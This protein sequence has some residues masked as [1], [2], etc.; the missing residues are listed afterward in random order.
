MK[1]DRFFRYV[2]LIFFSFLLVLS[3]CAPAATSLPPCPTVTTTSTL[4]PSP[5]RAAEESTR[6]TQPTHTARPPTLTLP[7][8]ATFINGSI[9]KIAFAS[10]DTRFASCEIFVINADGSQVIRLT[11]NNIDECCPDWS[12]DGSKLAFVQG[13]GIARE[14]WVMA[15][16]GSHPA[17]LTNNN[18]EDCC[19]AWSPDGSK[20]AFVQG[21]EREREIWVM[22]ADGSY[23]A[24]L[25]N[26]N[27][28]DCCLAWS[29]DGGKIAFVSNRDSPTGIYIMNADGSNPIRLAR[30][31][32]YFS[33]AW[34][35]DGARI[36]FLVSD[37]SV[38]PSVS[39][40]NVINADGSN[41]IQMMTTGDI[42]I[43]QFAWS[44]DGTKIAYTSC[45]LNFDS[46]E[47]Y[48]VNADGSNPTN[49]TNSEASDRFPVWSPKGAKLAFESGRDHDWKIY[50][51]NA[52]GSNPIRLIEDRDA[53]FP[54]WSPD[55]TKIAFID[56]VKGYI[57]VMNA[58][59]SA[60]ID[61]VIIAHTKGFS[62]QPILA[63]PSTLGPDCSLGWT[64][65]TTGML[66]QV[67]ETSSASNRVR[68]GPSRMNEVI[69]QLLPGTVVEVL[70][71]GKRPDPGRCWLDSG[72]RWHGVLF[73]ALQSVIDRP[74]GLVLRSPNTASTPWQARPP[75]SWIS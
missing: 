15:A 56:H 35:P 34:S 17:N 50:V 36:A 62:W 45:K 48:V 12:P 4:Q 39:A 21:S 3:A 23:A 52:D 71:G 10:C 20:L 74:F 72:R 63:T 25:T 32:H 58:D 16:D 40:I 38:N 51:M 67:S 30:T 59:G 33:P 31:N 60:L 5:T 22:A 18:A 43:G 29:P 24:N 2:Q 66:A 26:N 1:R 9:R 57:Y 8:T 27:A 46:C 65:L 53:N 49:L 11:N 54:V 14:I 64:R 13:S 73:G 41:L 61:S 69:A 44:P 6:T 75:G 19:L 47:I 42:P 70:E 7:P 55:G 28:E 37:F 68:S